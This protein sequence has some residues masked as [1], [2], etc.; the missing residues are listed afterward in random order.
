MSDWVTSLPFALATLLALVHVGACA[1]ALGVLPGNR[2]PSTAMAW[3][4]L[5]L[6]VPYFGILAFLL[7]GSTTVGRKRRDLQ[8]R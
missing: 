7:F 5:I 3:L 8:R 6:A 2:K 1:L 4:I